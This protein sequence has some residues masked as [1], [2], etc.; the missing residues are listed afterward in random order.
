MAW[1]FNSQMP[2][3][4]QIVEKLRS[5]ILCGKFVPGEQ[6]PTVRQLAQDAAVNPNTMQKAL[7]FLEAEGLLISH[8]TIG[9]FVTSD[10]EVLLSAKQSM[11]NAYLA[12]ATQHAYDLGITREM[13]IKYINESEEN[14]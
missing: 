6:F 5:D 12:E 14:V 2:V 8:S 1:K 13:I 3:C 10:T 9:R 4:H 11:Q 7:S